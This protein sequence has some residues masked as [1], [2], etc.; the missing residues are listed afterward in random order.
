MEPTDNPTPPIQPQPEETLYS[1]DAPVRPFKRRSK[2]FFTTIA[3]IIFLVSVILF[4]AKEF[5]LIGA[6]LATGFL[7]YVLASVEP[8]HTK[9]ILTNKGI[10][11]ADKLL[12]WDQLGRFWWQD[13]W[14]VDTLHV[15]T[16]T[17]FPGRIIMVL[18]QGDKSAIENHLKQYLIMEQPEP[19]WL[20]NA[21][22]W[23]S[24]KIPLESQDSPKS[25]DA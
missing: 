10:R 1:W 13:K 16:P 2:E 18:G 4:L 15:E 8:E 12:T 23:L 11:T 17:Q 25:K 9:H 20:D 24:D 21:S 22:Q 5:L 7:A 6:I 14:G 19:S 3:A